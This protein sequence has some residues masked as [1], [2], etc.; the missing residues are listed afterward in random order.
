MSYEHALKRCPFC[1]S[2]DVWLHP[3][4]ALYCRESIARV[5]CQACG[6]AGPI[7]TGLQ[8]DHVAIVLWHERKFVRDYTV[9]EQENP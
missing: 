8:A 4:T 5:E 2:T 1:N 3:I 9:E 7:A 6:C